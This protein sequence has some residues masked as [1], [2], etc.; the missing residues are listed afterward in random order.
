M[1]FSRE[2][3]CLITGANSGIGKAAAKGLAKLGA[4]II[5]VTRNHTRGERTLAELKAITGSDKFYL[6]I[7]DLSSQ[8]SI[9]DLANEIK[10]KFSSIDILINNAGAY[11]S[12]YLIKQAGENY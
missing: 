1:Y 6:F 7:T 9:L 3:N 12:K 5:L 8:K 4:T 10:N 2:I 11:F